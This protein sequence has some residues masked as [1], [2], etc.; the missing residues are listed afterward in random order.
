MHDTNQRIQTL[1]ETVLPPLAQAMWEFNQHNMEAL[2][3]GILQ[4]EDVYHVQL[5]IIS[6]IDNKTITLGQMPDSGFFKTISHSSPVF[7]KNNDIQLGQL[8]ISTTTE[9]IFKRIKKSAGQILL[10][11]A[12]MIFL[13]AFFIVWIVN[14]ILTRHLRDISNFMAQLNLSS[15]A[16]NLKLKRQQATSQQHDELDILVSSINKMRQHLI[17]DIAHRQQVEFELNQEKQEKFKLEQQQKITLAASEAK[18]EFLAAMS[19]EIRTPM[20]GVMGMLDILSKTQ[21]D[22]DQLYYL[23]MAITS[24]DSLRYIIDD[25]LDYSKLDAGKMILEKIPFNLES[26]ISECLQSIYIE[27]YNNQNL[28]LND[29]GMAGDKVAGDNIF[30][31]SLTPAYILGN[32]DESRDVY[33]SFVGFLTIF[34]GTQRIIRGNIFAEIYTDELPIVKYC[35]HTHNGTKV[36]IAPNL[37]NIES[38]TS[39]IDIVQLFELLND[40]QFSREY[41]FINFVQLPAKF[42]NGHHVSLKNEVEGIGVSIFENSILLY[43]RRC[44]FLIIFL[45][46]FY[47]EFLF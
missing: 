37:I 26:L 39:A 8:T 32:F 9:A 5:E 34:N 3:N 25:I 4:T 41:D 1:Q 21:L 2:L 29:A 45:F 43:Q 14:R 17:D 38:A 24:S 28:P 27:G 36:N 15:L 30:T 13:V 7:H 31:V 12:V 33:R 19:H 22:Q 40:L 18:G 42:A 10:S 16:Q 23:K 20:N 11:I 6:T 35:S 44:L 47:I 46:S